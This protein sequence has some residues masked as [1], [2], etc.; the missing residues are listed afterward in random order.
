MDMKTKE[1]R[2]AGSLLFSG[3][4]VKRKLLES[5]TLLG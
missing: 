2:N 3:I 5:R 4:E 1:T